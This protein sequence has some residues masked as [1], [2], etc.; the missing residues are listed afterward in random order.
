MRNTNDPSGRQEN[1]LEVWPDRR[2]NDV[3]RMP[4]LRVEPGADY[5]NHLLTPL[6][7]AF[8]PAFFLTHTLCL[9]YVSSRRIC[10]SLQASRYPCQRTDVYEWPKAKSHPQCSSCKASKC[11]R[12]LSFRE[13]GHSGIHERPSGRATVTSGSVEA[14]CY[15]CCE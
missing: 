3:I 8:S 14:I 9:R 5:I 13:R 7:S 6:S 1:E 2:S 11:L 12:E 15:D 4:S 10:A